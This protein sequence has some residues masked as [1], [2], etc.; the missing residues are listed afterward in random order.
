[1]SFLDEFFSILRILILHSFVMC[2]FFKMIMIVNS[3]IVLL[4]MLKLLTNV[5]SNVG[6]KL[7]GKERCELGP[8]YVSLLVT[9]VVIRQLIRI[10]R[11]I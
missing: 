8:K 5:T 6:C 3:D 1:M 11:L 9:H 4:L 2:C 7:L 10:K